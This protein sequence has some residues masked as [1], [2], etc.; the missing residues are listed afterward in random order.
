MKPQDIAIGETYRMRGTFGEVKS[1]TV[2]AYDPHGALNGG[3]V[4]ASTG[5]TKSGR[6]SQV[7]TLAGDY[8]VKHII[9]EPRS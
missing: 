5:P 1:R 3:T 9:H 2:V 8:F 6:P 4:R 7:E